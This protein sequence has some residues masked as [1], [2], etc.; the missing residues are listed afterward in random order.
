MLIPP[1]SRLIH[2][3]L[4]GPN[5]E[6]GA[7]CFNPPHPIDQDSEYVVMSQW[8][9]DEVTCVDCLEK[10][11]LALEVSR[12]RLLRNNLSIRLNIAFGMIDANYWNRKIRKPDEE[13]INPDSDGLLAAQFLRLTAEFDDLMKPIIA[14][15]AK[16]EEQFGWPELISEEAQ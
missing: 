11:G 10:M 13:K 5:G 2:K 9:H 1:E 4:I 14:M 6:T 12:G 7:L 15:M 16:H 3:G 8:L